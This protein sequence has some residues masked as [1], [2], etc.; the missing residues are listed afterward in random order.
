[1]TRAEA[2]CACENI[3]SLLDSVRES[4]AKF[5]DSFGDPIEEKTTSMRD[6]IHSK[7]QYPHITERMDA[8][9]RGMWNGVKKWDRNDEF[10]DNLLDG[11]DDVLRSLKN[12]GDETEPALLPESTPI[13]TGDVSP[14]L[15]EEQRA[16]LEQ[17]GTATLASQGTH[18]VLASQAAESVAEAEK[19][20][21]AAQI[22][23]QRASPEAAARCKEEAI[24]TVW[25]Q[26]H[27]RHVTV[28]DEDDVKYGRL[29]AILKMT[30]SDRTRQLIIAAFYAGKV[31]GVN[32]L[33]E[34]LQERV[35]K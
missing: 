3:L 16:V 1:M 15:S 20:V 19:A 10:N 35:Y 34:E 12:T 23:L 31:A 7:P 24:A 27:G 5:P 30:T 28:V 11:L 13:E 21:K 33:Y 26:L 14:Q 25:N 4:N 22:I 8:A 32:L 29:D 2:I 18:A 6:Y 9:L 17:I